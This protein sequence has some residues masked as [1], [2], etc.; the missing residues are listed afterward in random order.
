MTVITIAR[1]FGAG[2][3]SVAA[4][5]ARRLDLEVVDKTLIAEVARRATLPPDTVE[6][7]DEHMT[8]LVERLARLFA[9]IAPAYGMAWEPPYVDPAFDPRREVLRLTEDVI[10]ESAGRGGVVI[11][12]RGGAFVL[13]GR[14]GVLNAF[15]H[16]PPE[17]RLRAV[18][19]RFSLAEPEARRRIHE[20]DE[21]RTAY[22]RQLYAADWRDPRHYDLVLDTARLGHECTADVIVT[23]ARS[24][25]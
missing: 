6:A 9:P 1:E 25:L 21:N 13:A 16:A 8:P 14:P 2:G 19:E 23:A 15:L 24:R 20:T 3:S 22:M 7:V 5:V 10:R 18:M 17:I 11:V 4:I 12:G